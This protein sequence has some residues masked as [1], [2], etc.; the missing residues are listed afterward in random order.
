MEC[1]LS[2]TQR[3]QLPKSK[4][5]PTYSRYLRK[6]AMWAQNSNLHA[7]VTR[8]HQSKWLLQMI[9]PNSLPRVAA[10]FVVQTVC[11]VAMHAYNAVIAKF[12]M[13][14]F[15]VASLALVQCRIAIMLA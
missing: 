15:T 12:F 10:I 9:S 3:Q 7:R 13:P 8:I 11:I 6:T 5:G 4:C 1:T 14:L 2:A